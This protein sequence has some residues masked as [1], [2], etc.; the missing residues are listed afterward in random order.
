MKTFDLEFAAAT[1]K[2]I[3]IELPTATADDQAQA[4][5]FLS[6]DESRAIT[7]QILYVDHGTSLY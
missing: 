5:L 1:A 4:I 7:G 6:C 3:D 2:H